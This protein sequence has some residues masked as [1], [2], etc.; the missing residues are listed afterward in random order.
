MVEI[1]SWSWPQWILI[2]IVL[3]NVWVALAR[4]GK[5]KGVYRLTDIFFD[6]GS[7]TILLI[8]G[9]FFGRH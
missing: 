8:C 2:G 3:I 9:G 7:L 6:V 5:L 4:L 1:S